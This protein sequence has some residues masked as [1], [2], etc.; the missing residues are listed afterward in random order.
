MRQ[1][2]LISSLNMNFKDEAI[3]KLCS[4]IIWFVLYVLELRLITIVLDY[5][6]YNETYAK[7]EKEKRKTDS[8]SNLP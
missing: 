2:G 6:I 8:K 3:G 7:K 5:K 1:G 4:G